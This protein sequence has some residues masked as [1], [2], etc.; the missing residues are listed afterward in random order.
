[1]PLWPI[2]APGMPPIGEDFIAAAQAL[3]DEKT[4]VHYKG[5][6]I[7]KIEVGPILK[8]VIRQALYGRGELNI[9]IT[10]KA[11]KRALQPI[12]SGHRWAADRDMGSPGPEPCEVMILGKQLGEDEMRDCRCFVGPSG[13]LV[14]ETCRKLGI[15]GASKWYIANVVKT[16]LGESSTLT[17]KMISNFSHLL[18]QELRLVRPKYLLCF[19]A[20][21][22]KAVFGKS[23]TLAK[24]DGRVLPL[25]INMAKRAGDPPDMHKML[26]MGCRHPASVLRDPVWLGQFEKTMGRFRSLVE[27]D[28]WDG[29]EEDL[30]HRVIRDE[31]ELNAV[32]DEVLAG[33]RNNI[34]AFDAEWN[35]DHPENSNA[36]LRTVQFSWAHKKAAAIV[37]RAQGGA[38]AF[39]TRV[40]KRA[41]SGKLVRTDKWTTDQERARKVISRAVLRMCEP[42]RVCGHYFTADLE[43]LVPYGIDLRKK[44][45][46]PK[47]FEDCEH[48]GGLDTA[49][50][51]HAVNEVD[52]FS[53]T[54]QA[55]RYT[56]AP[57]YDV[58]VTE[59]K[60]AYCK[61][62]KIKEKNLEGYGD[63]PDE[64][65][66]P[67]GIYDADVTRRLAIRHK[68][69][70]SCDVY[71][72]NCWEAFWIS[73]RAALGVLEMKCTGFCI[74]LDR[75]D[76]VTDTFMMACDQLKDKIRDWAQ[77]PELNL[78]SVPQVSELLFG[79]KHNG[80]KTPDGTPVRLRP[81]GAK[82]LN[83]QPLLTTGKR[84]KL[85]A[86]LDEDEEDS[87]NPST[88]K[89]VLGML[90]FQDKHVARRKNGTVEIDAKE[91][92]GWLRDYRYASHVLKSVLKPPSVDDK[93]Q[94]VMRN[95]RRVYTAGLAAVA[96]DDGRVRTTIY[97]TKETGRWSS[98]RPPLQNLSKKREPD[99]KRILADAY[100][101]PLRSVLTAAPGHVLVEADYIGA[102][103][104]GMG[105]MSGDTLLLD[106]ARRNSLPEHDPDFYDIHSNVCV[107]AFR[108]DCPPTKAGLAA[109]GKA[110]MRNVAKAVVF[111]IAYGR[112]AK[113]I[114][115]AAKE[116]GVYVTVEEA[117]TVIDTIFD[118]YPGLVPFFEECKRRAVNDLRY[119]GYEEEG[120]R[121]EAPGWLCG[122]FGRYRRFPKTKDRKIAGEIERQAQNFP[123]QGMIADAVSLAVGNI[124]NYREKCRELDISEEELDYR[125]ILQVHDA[126]LL[127]V[128]A[129]CVPIVVD[130]VLP[131]N[132]VKRVPIFPSNLDGTPQ[133]GRGPYYLGVD[134]EVMTSWGLHMLPDE[135]QKLGIDPKYAGWK[136]TARG[137]EC[138]AYFPKKV[139]TDHGLVAV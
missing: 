21:A 3:G 107:L 121:T 103:L 139:W 111:G 38:P 16:G 133:E 73:Q 88:A 48:K 63:C 85:W 132:M 112:G 55:L 6:K 70:L 59:W 113:A 26:V 67:Y 24:A 64:V 75:V 108:Y 34:I 116:E 17:A 12:V 46:P 20:D 62:R 57:R 90:W 124:Y 98:A 41:S 82:S 102:E 65:L 130:T 76:E 30:D 119:R 117:Q 86:D 5:K 95:G 110:Y 101:W 78:N 8:D 94:Y 56:N 1:M 66:I 79:V 92:I 25:E 72:N 136:T 2:D 37:I 138:P 118:M 18:H 19:G 89:N 28:R 84:P 9:N 47:H 99:Y 68:K 131:F 44:F 80:K 54:G 50:M 120:P 33:K 100:R 4:K 97:Q 137:L 127:E 93:N 69:A 109:I 134:I 11:N 135:C 45:A 71:G 42:N 23:M 14:V 106:H 74:N 81:E 77:W 40:V 53:L 36:Y 15:K 39:K 49:Y 126:V 83:L 43:W 122:P 58:G 10:L 91:Q 129:R 87:S 104:F 52:D 7:D 128:P 32:V 27:G 22:L 114:S 35:G 51:A 60:K 115:I 123:I 13:E 96:C 29:V 125:M 61:E 105:I 31:D